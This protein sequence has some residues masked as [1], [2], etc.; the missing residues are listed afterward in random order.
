MHRKIS[1]KSALLL[2]AYKVSFE[3]TKNQ[4]TTK[5]FNNICF[6]LLIL[7]RNFISHANSFRVLIPHTLVPPSKRAISATLSC[8]FVALP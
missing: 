5:N 6:N 7:I 3:K 1:I 8:I 4:S 2:D